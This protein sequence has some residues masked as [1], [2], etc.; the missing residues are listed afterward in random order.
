[1]PGPAAD[2]TGSVTGAGGDYPTLRLLI[3]G[4]WRESPDAIPVEDPATEEI[5]GKLPCASAADIEEALAACERGFATWRRTEP[6]ER[7]VI[8]R[9][10]AR[11]VRERKAYIAWVITRELGK[12]LAEALAE[13]D[14]A[15]AILEWNAEEGRRGYGRIIPGPPHRRQFVSREPVGPVAAF[16]PWNAPLIT[17]S[18]KISSALAAG[19]PVVM[20]PAEETPGAALCLAQAFVEAGL[21]A[22]ALSV[23]FGDPARISEQLLG[24]PVIRAV[25]FTGSTAVGKALAAL[26]AATMKRAVMEL[27]GH[28]PVVVC[29]DVAAQ[30][31]AASAARAAYRN[32]GQVCTSPTRFFVH[33]SRYDEFVSALTRHVGSLR[34][35]NGLAETTDMG[36][37]ASPRRLEAIQDLVDDAVAHGA[38]VTTGGQRRPGRGYFYEPTVLADV[39][40]QCKISRIEPFGPVATVA[41]FDDLQSA[42]DQ[43]NR[44]PYGLAG[45]V[46][47]SSA[48]DIRRLTADLDCGAIAVNHWQVSGP[49]T[50]FG[51]HKDSGLGSEGG[52]EGIAA[53]QQVKFVSEQ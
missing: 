20:K 5:L 4:E 50:P 31:V 39:G 2:G 18:R 7:C 22:G 35:G 16:A 33:R 23:I 9:A 27:G 36:P 10:A 12:P 48:A 8:I 44:V 25:T 30:A 19:C 37:V 28:A 21:P 42:I 53:F 40:D 46:F 43:A 26:A 47:A 51:G 11:L 32:A 38:R 17:P 41:A 49:E 6:Q 13:V 45:Y 24:S 34:L 1:M 29:A 15:A 52:I 3:G 14:T